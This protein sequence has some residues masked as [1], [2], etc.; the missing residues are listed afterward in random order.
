MHIFV[1]SSQL[2]TSEKSP[3][4]VFKMEKQ[5]QETKAKL[6]LFKK[7]KKSKQPK[8]TRNNEMIHL[9]KKPREIFQLDPNAAIVTWQLGY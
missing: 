8:N 5:N 9:M 3:W 4:D 2:H 6:A 7:K 1:L